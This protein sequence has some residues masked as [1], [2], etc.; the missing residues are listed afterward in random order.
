MSKT[1]APRK[2]V[3]N[4]NG[5]RAQ[6]AAARGE[7]HL[8]FEITPEDSEEPLSF[9]VL[10]RNWWPVK[11]LVSMQDLDGDVDILRKVMGETEFDRLVE[12]GFD[13]GDMKFL[14]KKIMGPADEGDDAGDDEGISLG[15]ASG[16]SES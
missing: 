13:V 5:L 15:E 9:S 6:Q 7:K 11:L 1:G 4:L 10:R 12:T 8:S 2:A 3:L 16:S 14:F